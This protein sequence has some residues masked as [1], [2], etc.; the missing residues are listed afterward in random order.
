MTGRCARAAPTGTILVYLERHAVVDL[1][2]DRTSASLS[3]WLVEHPGVEV[4]AR[5]L[6]TEYAKCASQG[7]PTA[8]QV[9]DC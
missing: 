8:V 2:S 6:S 9:A 1:L 7:A 3:A 5:D 4:I